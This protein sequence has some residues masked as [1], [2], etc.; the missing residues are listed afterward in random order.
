MVTSP[1]RRTTHLDSKLRQSEKRAVFYHL[2]RRQA[3]IPKYIYFISHEPGRSVATLTPSGHAFSLSRIVTF[4]AETE[5]IVK[6]LAELGAK[7]EVD[8]VLSLSADPEELPV[9]YKQYMI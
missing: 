2:A 5:P 3:I 1:C 8:F 4:L 7:H 6:V 9:F